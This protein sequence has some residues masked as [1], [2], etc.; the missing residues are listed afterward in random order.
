VRIRNVLKNSTSD[1]FIVEVNVV[2]SIHDWV[3][4]TGSCAHICS[5]IEAL[6][7]R[8]KLHNKEI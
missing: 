2:T 7:N 5:N 3:L 8:R 4:D 6:K 1:I